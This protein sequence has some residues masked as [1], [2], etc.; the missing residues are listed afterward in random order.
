MQTLH[1]DP[2]KLHY[3][4]SIAAQSAFTVR[5]LLL[6][7]L[8]TPPPQNNSPNISEKPTELEGSSEP[9]V[10]AQLSTRP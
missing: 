1:M 2:L 6:L 4:V 5:A 10:T 9:C 8:H 7:N 3:R